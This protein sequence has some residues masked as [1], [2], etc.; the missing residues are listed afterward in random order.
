MLRLVWLNKTKADLAD[1]TF[2]KVD[3]YKFLHQ[4]TAD[5][6]EVS[7][8]VFLVDAKDYERLPEAKIELDALVSL[9]SRECGISR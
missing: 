4:Q 9:R 6:V 7:G 1:S 2:L 8:I 5:G 3:T